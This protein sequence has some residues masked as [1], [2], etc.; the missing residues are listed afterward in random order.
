MPPADLA[1]HPERNV[2]LSA[3]L[4]GDIEQIDASSK[5]VDL[6]PGDILV[7]A[8]DGLLSLPGAEIANLLGKSGGKSA[9]V[10]AGALLDAVM[11]KKNER[12]DNTTVAVVHI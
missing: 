1:T 11:A 6:L 8:S 9:H 5:P 4:G 12:Q 3:L 7:A 10:I 2:L